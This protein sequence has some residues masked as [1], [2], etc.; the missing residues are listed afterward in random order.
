MEYRYPL[1][2][3][4]PTYNRKD[5]LI[6]LYES[7]VRQTFS[8]FQWLIIDD[9]S[10][11][12]TKKIIEKM[13]E[14]CLDIDYF[15]KENG[16]KHTALNYAHPYIKGELLCIVD[17]DD[18]LVKDAVETIIEFWEQYKTVG[19]IKCMAFLKG[20]NSYVSLS[21]S[22]PG[23]P[24]ISNHIDFRVNGKRKGDCCEVLL[25]NIFKEFPFP[26]FKEE[27]FMGEGYLWNHVGFRYDTVYIN[28]IIYICEYLEGGLTRSGRR[29]R[30]E[31]PKGG[32]ENCNSFMEKFEMPRVLPE[33]LRKE[34]WMFICYGKF[35]GY[36]YKKILAKCHQK[37]LIRKNYLFGVL[38]YFFW[39]VKYR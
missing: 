9:G 33:I 39:R 27:R 10:T 6:S 12:G 25:S 14:K 8:N 4:T 7:L 31:C 35:A 15:Y 32:M 2:I 3:L 16:G 19:N 20:T 11:D 23:E 26:E 24:T 30:I 28:K 37:E 17:S 38:L 36:P 21:N 18:W 13:S 22:F 29:L 5:T 34:A 1:T